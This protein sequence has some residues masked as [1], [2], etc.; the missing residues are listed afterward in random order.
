MIE[1]GDGLLESARRVGTE[2]ADAYIADAVRLAL[3]FDRVDLDDLSGERDIEGLLLATQNRERHGRWG[4]GFSFARSFDRHHSIFIFLE[5][6]S[7]GDRA[8]A[9]R[10]SGLVSGQP[11]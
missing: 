1:V 10:L 11:D 7:S 6:A 8:P 3:R 5:N 4:W 9:G 2:L